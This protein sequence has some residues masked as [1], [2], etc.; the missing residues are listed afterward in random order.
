MPPAPPIVGK[1]IYACSKI[2]AF[3][4]TDRDTN[5]KVY[6]NG[7]PHVQ[8]KSGWGQG[9]IELNHTLS[10]GDSVS[11][12][13]EKNGS[14]SVPTIKP[15]KVIKIPPNLIVP[16]R[17]LN[18]PEI[19]PPLYE[20][21]RLVLVRNVL[22]GATV[23]LADLDTPSYSL[24]RT[25]YN[26]A[27]IGTPPLKI[28]VGEPDPNWLMTMQDFCE[29][30]FLSDW[31]KKEYIQ[32]VPAKLKE[33]ILQQPV[34]GHDTVIVHN[35]I[36]GAVIEIFAK[37]K[38]GGDSVKVGGGIVTDY[39]NKV[40]INPPVDA[41]N[42]NY[43]PVQSLCDTRAEGKFVSPSLTIP[44]PV[45][46]EPLCIT[47]NEIVVCNTIPLGT[48]EVFI[49]GQS[50]ETFAGNGDCEKAALAVKL[51]AND[52]VTARQFVEGSHKPSKL[53][54][55]AIV[56]SSGAP[57][58]DPAKWNDPHHVFSNNCY[59]YACDIMT[60][61]FA[62]PGLAHGIK[63][64]AIYCPEVGNAAIADG[65]KKEPEKK[66][67]GCTHLIALVVGTSH[68]SGNRD[69]HWYRLDN[70]GLW[71]H[72]PASLPVSDRDAST[73]LI[74]NPETANRDYNGP[75][76]YVNYDTFCTY[77]CVDKRFAQIK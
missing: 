51:S 58:Y 60:D 57:S 32:R 22:E 71:S 44:I 3:G 11:A 7:Y 63:S 41:R 24:G 49:N 6:I 4:G 23:R 25:P 59:N 43:G 67:L 68:V 62:Q 29:P 50:I 33:P 54:K 65:L 38:R 66:C 70:N 39:S 35:L 10:A 56:M 20:C 17:K 5:I 61:T 18:P 73:K 40:P 12:T 28:D 47:D 72:K 26:I 45:I 30:T 53:S 52:K 69:F 37:P 34:D 76:Y 19:V 31:S 42:F 9:E 14:T 64:Y 16:V 1:P 13:A 15:I 46:K 21:Q 8:I 2:I 74:K 48:I 36:I 75:D 55:A 77:F 27:R